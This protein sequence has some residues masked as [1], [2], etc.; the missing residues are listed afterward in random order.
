MDKEMM[1]GI[2]GTMKANGTRELS[3]DEMDKV[4]GGA[5]FWFFDDERRKPRG[6][7][8]IQTTVDRDSASE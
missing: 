7:R 3:L 2:N 4:I 6:E 5:S 1:N 8:L